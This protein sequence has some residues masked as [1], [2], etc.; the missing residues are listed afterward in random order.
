MVLTGR[1]RAQQAGAKGDVINILNEQSKRV[2]Q[3]AVSGPG[4]VMIDGGTAKL[5]AN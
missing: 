2:I 1:G 3:A 5:A 4:E